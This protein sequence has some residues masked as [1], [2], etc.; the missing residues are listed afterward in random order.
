[1][2]DKD[3]TKEQLINELAKLCQR[4]AELEASENELK[5]TKEALQKAHNE[6]KRQV[7][8]HTAELAVVNKR[9]RGEIEERKRA[10]K[11]LRTT[12][13][14]SRNI[15]NSSLDM[16]ITVDT[17]R[18]IVEFNKAAEETFGY[19][20]EEV[21]GTSVDTL[22][23]NPQEALAVHKTTVEQGQCIQEI[24][25]KRKNGEVFPSFL[26]ASLLRDAQGGAVG[27]MGVSRDITEQKRAE[28]A[29]RESEDRYRTIFE[30]TGTA[31]I[32]SDED[33]TILM[34]NSEFENLSGYSKKEIEGKKS[35]T[36]FVV[37]DDLEI[38]KK[39]HR[40][41]RID[42]NSAPR[43]H[44]FRFK[45]RHGNFRYVFA[46]VAMIPGT[47]RG[48]ASFMDITNLKRA[49]EQLLIKQKLEGVIEMAGAACHEI[50][51][52]LMTV[53]GT[54]ELLMMGMEESNPYYEK[55]KT[56]NEQV[57]RMA[58]ITRKIMK[59]KKYETME[60]INGKVVDIDK[61]SK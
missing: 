44:E 27:V 16:I 9:L 18:Y 42:P 25:N 58:E 17:D 35:W 7:E 10:E 59:I 57:G 31:T 39:Y 38:L 6:L 12:Q 30:S 37:Q 48:V 26:S 5:Q 54:C 47:K 14:Y 53:S 36:K 19:L 51:Q 1:M 28:E 43:N 21:V 32:I 15:I 55:I 41:R 56:I 3:K 11:A 29:L 20:R 13:E 23:A 8:E 22:Y 50:N 24:L 61:A 46:T 49:E 4:I 2:K 40:L 45:D 60:Y 34:V 52:P 33:M